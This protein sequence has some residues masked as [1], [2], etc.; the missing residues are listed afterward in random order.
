MTI[1]KKRKKELKKLDLFQ[2]KSLAVLNWGVDNKFK[3]AMYLSP[4]LFILAGIF[5]WNYLQDQQAQSRR[6][7]L[8]AIDKIFND[9]ELNFSKKQNKVK[10]LIK[11]AK[12]KENESKSKSDKPEDNKSL[13]Q[14]KSIEA[15][16]NQLKSIKVDHSKSRSMYK[17]FY[18]KNLNN[19]EGWRAGLSQVDIFIKEKDYKPA[20]QILESILD[21]SDNLAFYSIQVRSMYIALLEQQQEY[22]SALKQIDALLAMENQESVYPK[23]LFMKSRILHTKG[24]SKSALDILSKIET[25]HNSSPEAQKAKALKALW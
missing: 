1:N 23:A 20:S 10:S 16:E 22:D 13:S 21:K 4:A 25:E 14:A 5:T 6:D 11:D 8:A 15:L 3:I 24:D 12:L 2:Q 7:E 17:D 9:E 19:R 18:E